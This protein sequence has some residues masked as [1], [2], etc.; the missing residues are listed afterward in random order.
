[1][2]SLSF[3]LYKFNCPNSHLGVSLHF[4]TNFSNSDF[5]LFCQLLFILKSLEQC[6][7]VITS[8]K[9]HCLK[10]NRQMTMNLFPVS[11]LGKPGEISGKS[12][13]FESYS[14][15]S[16]LVSQFPDL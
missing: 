2:D 6:L 11:L 9:N 16:E 1:M 4:E 10:P 12:T 15:N 13:G 14:L 3:F 7:G 5:F 8:L